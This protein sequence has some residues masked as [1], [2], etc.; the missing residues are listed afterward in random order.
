MIRV[1]NKLDGLE[2]HI[3]LKERFEMARNIDN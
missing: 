3:L 1:D 2:N